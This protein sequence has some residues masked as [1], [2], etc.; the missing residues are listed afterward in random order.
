MTIDEIES[1]TIK[2]LLEQTTAEVLLPNDLHDTFIDLGIN[3]EDIEIT[4]LLSMIK[5]FTSD[6]IRTF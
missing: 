3:Y 1:K 2:V 6:I 5:R 4:Y